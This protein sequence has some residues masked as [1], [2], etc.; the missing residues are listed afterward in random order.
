MLRLRPPR[1]A[2]AEQLTEARQALH[3]LSTKQARAQRGTS[4]SGHFSLDEVVVTEVKDVLA[5]VDEAEAKRDP[6]WEAKYGEWSRAAALALIGSTS[7][8]TPPQP[9][10]TE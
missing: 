6:E 1:S 7:P 10:T 4:S 9:T 5:A 2:H 8:S 3:E